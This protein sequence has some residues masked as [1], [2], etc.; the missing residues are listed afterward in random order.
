MLKGSRADTDAVI[1][2]MTKTATIIPISNIILDEEI[3]P[4]GGVDQRRVSIFAENIRDGFKFDRKI[5]GILR[6][7]EDTTLIAAG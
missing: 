4:R 7:H 3:Y 6:S 1:I 5:V 2:A